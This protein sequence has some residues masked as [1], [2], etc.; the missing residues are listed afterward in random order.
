MV[1]SGEKT[2]PNKANFKAVL[3]RLAGKIVAEKAKQC[4]F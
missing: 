4:G 2:K 1:G 3:K